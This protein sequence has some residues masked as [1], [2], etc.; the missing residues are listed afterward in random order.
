M[1]D[2]HGIVIVFNPD[3]PSHLKEIEM[4]YSCFVQQQQLLDSQ[5]ILIAHHK[6]GSAGDTENLT[7]CKMAILCFS[8]IFIAPSMCMAYGV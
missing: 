5:C 4:L 7:L 6:P 3:L 2:S 8:I 1:K